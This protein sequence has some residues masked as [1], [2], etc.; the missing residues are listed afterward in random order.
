MSDLTMA[1]HEGPEFYELVRHQ[2]LRGSGEKNLAV[3]SQYDHPFKGLV[4]F[5]SSVPV[6]RNHTHTYTRSH[7]HEHSAI[8]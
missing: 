7:T 6:C 1:L 3:I 5:Y 2:G 8:S 4:P